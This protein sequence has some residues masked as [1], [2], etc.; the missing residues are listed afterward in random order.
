[1]S[2]GDRSDERG[3]SGALEVGACGFEARLDEPEIAGHRDLWAAAPRELAARHGIS[4]ADFGPAHCVLISSLPEA[5]VVNHVLGLHDATAGAT[6][7]AQIERF[8]AG[9]GVPVLIAVRDGASAEGLLAERRYERGYAWVKFER[10]VS[11]PVTVARCEFAVRA[12]EPHDAE[13]MGRVVADGFGLPADLSS[14][15]AALVGRRRWHCLGAYDGPRLVACGTLYVQGEAGWLTWGATAPGHRG[16]GA[17]KALLGARIQL[18]RRLGLQT[19]VT[20]TGEREA[21]RSDASYRNI[22]GAG[23]Q[24][25]YRRPFWRSAA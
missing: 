16:R 6:H 5:R 23:F 7:L 13:A 18:A 4:Q 20:E 10:D 9:R 19:L 17:Q 2:A 21:G 12:V 14:W 25:R 22:I 15:F 11:Q 3:E 8:H 1:L 24:P